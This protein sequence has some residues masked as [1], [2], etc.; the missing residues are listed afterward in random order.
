MP[1]LPSRPAFTARATSANSTGRTVGDVTALAA[2]AT[3]AEPPTGTTLAAS[4]ALVDAGENTTGRRAT[5]GTADTA[6]GEVTALT[7]N[8]APTAGQS[9]AVLAIAEG[10]A[11]SLAAHSLATDATGTAGHKDNIAGATRTAIATSGTTGPLGGIEG[12]A[13]QHLTVAAI[14]TVAGLAQQPGVTTSRTVSGDR[15]SGIR[16]SPA[17]VATQTTHAPDRRATRAAVTSGRSRRAVGRHRGAAEEGEATAL[18]ASATIAPQRATATAGTAVAAGG[19]TRVPNSWLIAEPPQPPAPPSPSKP[20]KE[21][22]APPS[23]PVASPP[24]AKP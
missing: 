7:A 24:D 19:I 10:R 21:L 12:I 11:V 3:G 5:T 16:G 4:T 9:R 23:P 8:T 2:G 18:A 17:T 15:R 14:A 6:L 13:E 1:A 22:P 20:K